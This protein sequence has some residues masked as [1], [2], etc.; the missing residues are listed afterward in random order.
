MQ[1]KK[2]HRFISQFIIKSRNLSVKKIESQNFYE[3]DT[4]DDDISSLK[5]KKR[6]YARGST[7]P[8][9]PYTKCSTPSLFCY[10]RN[11]K[12]SKNIDRI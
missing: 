11:T 4:L 8:Y 7:F 9:S 6:T 5:F 1:K 2:V 3:D 12:N 10:V